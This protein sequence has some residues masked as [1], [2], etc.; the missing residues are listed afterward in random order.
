MNREVRP[1]SDAPV[2]AVHS[3]GL[4]TA[5]KSVEE[6]PATRIESHDPML[7]E[8]VDNTRLA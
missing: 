8:S 3:G 6:K 1:G 5:V 4:V 2:H 7:G